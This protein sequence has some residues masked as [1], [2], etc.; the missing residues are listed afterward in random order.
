LIIAYNT[1]M[2]RL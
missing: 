1:V 2:Q